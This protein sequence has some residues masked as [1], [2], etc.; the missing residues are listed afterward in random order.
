[1]KHLVLYICTV[2]ALS[3]LADSAPIFDDD[4]FDFAI[5]DL[6]VDCTK[7]GCGQGINQCSKET[8]TSTDTK[9]LTHTVKCFN[10]AGKEENEFV[11]NS[12]NPNPGSIQNGYAYYG[13]Y[14]NTNTVTH[15]T[16]NNVNHDTE[17]VETFAK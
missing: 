6:T 7:M 17:A 8:K 4:D 2:F 15:H 5:P 13:S 16:N 10:S 11:T 9:T 14:S 3:F 1:M 12:T